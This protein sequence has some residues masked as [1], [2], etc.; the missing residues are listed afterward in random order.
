MPII[1]THTKK[2]YDRY[3]AQETTKGRR[4]QTGSQQW[5]KMVGKKGDGGTKVKTN[6]R[7]INGGRIY[8]QYGSDF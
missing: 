2:G 1:Y 4:L 7:C 3:T 8:Q 6:E 5:G